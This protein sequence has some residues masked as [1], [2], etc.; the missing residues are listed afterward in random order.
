MLVEYAIS[1]GEG[2]LVDYGKRRYDDIPYRLGIRAGTD[3]WGAVWP[4][5]DLDAGQVI[6]ISPADP[7]C[8]TGE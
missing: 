6:I 3:A 4:E 5:I 8:T 1:A 2:T 7:D